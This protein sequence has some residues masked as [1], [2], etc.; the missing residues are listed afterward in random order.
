MFVSLFLSP[1]N[2]YQANDNFIADECLWDEND[3]PKYLKQKVSC[4]LNMLEL[5][6]VQNTV[7]SKRVLLC[8]T[9]KYPWLLQIT[10]PG[11]SLYHP[12]NNLDFS[13]NWKNYAKIMNKDPQVFQSKRLYRPLW[14]KHAVHI[15]VEATTQQCTWFL[16]CSCQVS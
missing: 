11:Y 16:P 8:S 6:N 1:E 2:W 9:A 5:W 15:I 10:F 13:S 12:R 3:M 7:E 14:I 4:E